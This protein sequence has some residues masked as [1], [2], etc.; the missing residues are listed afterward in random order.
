MRIQLIQFVGMQV[1]QEVQ[2]KDWHQQAL[3]GLLKSPLVST[4][5]G[6]AFTSIGHL[7]KF[8]L[9]HEFPATKAKKLFYEQV[10]RELYCFLKGQTSK[11]DLHAAGVVIWDADM[12]RAN[13]ESIGPIY[14]HQWRNWGGNINTNKDGF[15]QLRWAVDELIRTN[16]QTRRAVVSAWNAP[17]VLSN[18]AVLPPCHVLFQFNIIN[19]T[20]YTDVY[21]RSADAFLGLP[22]DVAT[23]ATISSLVA[24][25]LNL[26]AV[27][28]PVTN[29]VLNYHV[30]NLHL[31]KAHLDAAKEEINNKPSVCRPY[32]NTHNC[33][34]DTFHYNLCDLNNYLETRIIK[35]PL[36]T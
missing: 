8:D 6:F 12:K 4:R 5:V 17:Q 19:N 2:N 23:F 22:F 28:D 9:S 27:A 18:D 36:L 11:A 25:E 13:A 14:G 21:Q 7:F 30:S 34:V 16:G 33:T 3:V 29:E 20:L 26:R 35:A 1:K 31:Y 10:K 15:D 32:I 24:N